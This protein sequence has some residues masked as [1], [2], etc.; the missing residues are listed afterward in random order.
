MIEKDINI[1]RYTK[2]DLEK[3]LPPAVSIINKTEKAQSKYEEGIIQ[4]KRFVP[5]IRSMYISKNFIEKEI[6][7]RK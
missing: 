2:A 4:F 7:K 6:A 5:I 1:E 3:A